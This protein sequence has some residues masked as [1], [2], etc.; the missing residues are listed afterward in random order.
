[1]T[2]K[3]P[4]SDVPPKIHEN[5]SS[6]KEL[7]DEVKENYDVFSRLYLKFTNQ[8]QKV[9]KLKESF[10]LKFVSKDDFEDLMLLA[11]QGKLNSIDILK[12]CLGIRDEIQ[13]KIE[14]FESHLLIYHANT[15]L[16]NLNFDKV[17]DK[18]REAYINTR[19]NLT[20]LKLLLS[21]FNSLVSSVEKLYKALEAAEINFRRFMEKKDKLQGL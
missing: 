9:E 7:M 3:N 6:E 10:P 1:M 4:A 15:H 2:N 13:I 14:F 8:F 20:D 5:Y 18:T 19:K 17:T 11:Q 21:R 16:A 12:V